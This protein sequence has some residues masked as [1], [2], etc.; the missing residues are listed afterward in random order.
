[1]TEV[2]A[3]STHGIDLHTG[4]INRTNLPQIRANLTDEETTRLAKAF[5]VPVI[6][7]ANLR[8]GSLREAVAEH[9]IPML[10]YEAGEALRFDEIPIR[11]GLKGIVNVMRSLGMLPASRTRR[12]AAPEP[13]V[14]RS[15]AWVRAPASGLFRSVCALGSRVKRGEVLG[16]IDDPFSGQDLTVNAVTSGIVI[17]RSEIPLVYEG[18]ALFHIARFEDVREVANQVESFHIEH[19]PL[20]DDGSEPPIV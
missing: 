18:E 5:G 8:D 7:N 17:G 2:V 12:K 16:L 9:G 6:I 14:A 15:S 3:N 11:A 4:A 10:V 1:M 20:D 19:A 13:F